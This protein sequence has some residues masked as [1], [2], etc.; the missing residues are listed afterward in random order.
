MIKIIKNELI[1]FLLI[2]LLLALL[3]HSDLLHSPIARIN[4][5]S[6]KGNY[7][8]PLIWASGLYIIV[9]LVRLII[10]YILYLKNKKS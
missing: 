2:L 7:L 8:H 10:K 6:E 5:M 1:Y 4:L 3:Q 9:I